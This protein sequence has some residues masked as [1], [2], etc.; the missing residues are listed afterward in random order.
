MKTNVNK[1]EY[2]IYN[3]IN[4]NLHCAINRKSITQIETIIR[5]Y[6]GSE[7]VPEDDKHTVKGIYLENTGNN[8]YNMINDNEV[9]IMIKY[10]RFDNL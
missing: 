1:E 3:D 10:L 8:E 4:K 2:A 6:K 7:S 9:D 5:K